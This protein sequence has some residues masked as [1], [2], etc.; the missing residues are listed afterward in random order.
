M[1]S[2]PRGDDASPDVADVLPEFAAVEVLPG[3]VLVVDEV[4][5]DPVDEVEEALVLRTMIKLHPR[6]NVGTYEEGVDVD[7]DVDVVSDVA[8]PLPELPP[9][10][11]LALTQLESAL[12]AMVIGAEKLWAPVLSFSTSML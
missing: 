5:E 6:G 8:E 7:V 11:E 1:V 10:L 2:W 12:F 4:V 3:F 9:P